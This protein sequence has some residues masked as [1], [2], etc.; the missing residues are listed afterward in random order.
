[1]FKDHETR[2]GHTEYFLPGIEIKDFNVVIDCK[3]FFDQPVKNYIRRYD[4][5][6]KNGTGQGDNYTSGYLFDYHTYH[7]SLLVSIL[8]HTIILIIYY[9][10]TS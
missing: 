2:T 5:V 10:H 9:Y 4:N 8:T 7:T 6:R 1:M 3:S